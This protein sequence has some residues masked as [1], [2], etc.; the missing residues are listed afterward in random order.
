L[1]SL[2]ET[3]SEEDLNAKIEE[4]EGDEVTGD[5]WTCVFDALEA[6]CESEFISAKPSIMKHLSAF[7]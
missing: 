3:P 1:G 2:G 7:K 6:H 5:T 4:L